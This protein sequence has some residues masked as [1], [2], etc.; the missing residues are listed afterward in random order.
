MVPRPAAS[1]NALQRA[2]IAVKCPLTGK[3]MED[4][5]ILAASGYSYERSAIVEWMEKYSTEP[6]TGAVV[7]DARVITNVQLREFIGELRKVGI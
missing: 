5:V 6:R 1:P 4:P 3:V 2:S 7:V